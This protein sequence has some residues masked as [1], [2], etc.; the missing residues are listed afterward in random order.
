MGSSMELLALMLKRGLFWAILTVILLTSIHSAFAEADGGRQIKSEGDEPLPSDAAA[1]LND[2]K[3]SHAW[4][5]LMV[6]DRDT[7]EVIYQLNPDKMF[8][9]GSTTKLY[10]AAAALDTL[11]ADYSFKTP[12]YARGDMNESGTLHGDLI[13]VASGDLTMGGRTNH[14]GKIAYTDIDHSDANAIGNATLTTTNPLAG[15]DHLAGQ[16]AAA[17]IKKVVGE[18]IVDDRLFEKFSPEGSEGEYLLTPIIIND[19]LID[20]VVTPTDPG[21]A[22]EVEWRPK[23]S[24]YQVSTDVTTVEPEEPVQINVTS[25]GPGIIVVKG[26]VPSGKGPIVRT[27][28]VDD[29][30]SFAR[31]LLIEA[32]ERQGVAV[33]TSPEGK[34]PSNLLPPDM[35]YSGFRRVALLT[36]PPFS[37]N[38][39]LILK[40]SQNM[41]ADTLLPLMAVKGGKKSFWDGLDMEHPFLEKAGLDLDGVSIADGRGNANA[42]FMTPNATVQLLRYMSSRNDSQAYLDAL[43]ILGVDGSLATAVGPDSPA[44]GNVQ[45]KTG[46]TIRYDAVN[47]RLL[48]ASKALAGYMTTSSGRRLAFAIYVN[49]VGIEDVDG[50]LQVGNDL[51]RICEAIYKAN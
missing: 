9:P 32:L 41:H 27:Y 31:S 13:L 28:A 38:I 16:V 46:T 36:S 15:L 18:V 25:G 12:I 40:V 26:Q 19:N 21:R 20:L 37:E 42:D 51:G 48:L 39:K 49:N 8:S 24:V 6:E 35:N 7:S 33:N 45:A 1:I 3:Y 4:W 29:P 43:P 14:D 22:A 2:P 30:P 17:G 50:A 34:N 10:T 11:G 23:T 5:G 47:A 44:R